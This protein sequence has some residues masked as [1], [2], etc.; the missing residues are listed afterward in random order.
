MSVTLTRRQVIELGEKAVTVAREWYP[1]LFEDESPEV[2][3][4]RQVIAQAPAFARSN[5]HYDG[6][7]CPMYQ[8]VFNDLE[9][10]RSCALAV[11]W[12]NVTRSSCAPAK[13][14]RVNPRTDAS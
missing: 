2:I 3:A 4:F 13:L 8:T 7:D 14:I 9:N 6:V 12:D 1:K 5:C 10:H 11:A